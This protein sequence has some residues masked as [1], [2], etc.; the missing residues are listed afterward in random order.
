MKL[1]TLTA[2]LLTLVATST[3][4][5]PTFYGEIDASIDYLPEKNA[6][7]RDNDVVEISSNSSFVGL[8]G[9][10]KL[11]ERL[12]AVYGI[13]WGISTDGDSADWTQRNRFVGL[14]DAK[15]GTLK[16]GAHDTPVKQ[17]SSAVDTFNNYVANKADIGGIFS[18]ENRI[19][20][21]VLYESP[22]LKVAADA[23]IKVNAL[24]ATG[25][26]SGIDNSKAGVAKADGRGLGD[27]W[28]ASASYES[29]LFVAGIGYDKAI[30]SN[31]LG[32]GFL[33]ASDKAIVGGSLFAAANTLRAI[34]RVNPIQ[35]LA[36][37]ALYQT[38]E[39]EEAKGN[40]AAAVN[41]DDAQG[42]LVGAEYNLA[43]AKNWTVKAQYSQNKTSFKNATTDFDAVQIIGGVDYAFNKQ[44][45]TY[46]YAGYLT[47]EQAS[48]K[49]KQP[50]AGLGL[51]YK[52]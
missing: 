23:A 16:I 42:W 46:G 5:G 36:L 31:F 10:E 3:F 13:E 47:L 12:S 11:N 51:E 14:K 41:I 33:N 48:K 52:F 22:A 32:R 20:N 50:V 30:P 44:V 40:A 9:D 18:G 37:K 24:L 25:E 19:S 4:A 39:V 28:S 45:K 35:G 8:K 17:L 26:A 29:P 38:S 15:L 7:S 43:N 34:G 1:K 49:D 6:N 21:V 2:A 27:A